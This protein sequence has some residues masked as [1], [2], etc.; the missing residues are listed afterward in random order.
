MSEHKSQS[1]IFWGLLLVVLGV[2]FLFDQMGRLD[3]GDLLGRYW[4][5]VFILIG[6][7][8]LLSNNFKN[9]GSGVFFIL[10]GAF[11][12]LMRMRIFERDLW[13]Y[14]WP[15]AIVGAGLWILLRPAFHPGRTVAAAGAA[16]TLDIKQ[17]FSGT[18]RTIESQEFRGGQVEV[19]FGSAELDLR[20]ARLAG[21]QA[22]LDLSAVF[23]GIDVRVPR[24]WQIVLE[25]TPVLGS[26]EA[27]KA[28]GPD[29]P[30]TGTLT[31]HGSAVFGAIDIKD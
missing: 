3:F 15:L 18:S 11:F 2:L 7:S 29:V 1:R 23:G 5:V 21:G 24:D 19:V 31:V 26:I 27:R 12:L 16:D 4:P 6:V 8:I 17:V 22:A 10:F 30:K 25:G 28:A 9:V 20:N 14:I 13:H